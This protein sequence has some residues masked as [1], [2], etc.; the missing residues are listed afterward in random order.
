MNASVYRNTKFE[1]RLIQQGPNSFGLV[2]TNRKNISERINLEISEKEFTDEEISQIHDILGILE[3]KFEKVYNRLISDPKFL[4]NEIN[5]VKKEAA[6]EKTRLENEINLSKL[7][8][9]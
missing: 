8:K 6:I 4:L 9:L 7:S 5:R 1:I 3:E 2:C